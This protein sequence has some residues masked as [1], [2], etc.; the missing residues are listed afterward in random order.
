MAQTIRSLQELGEALGRGGSVDSDSRSHQTKD[1][2]SG[3]NGGVYHFPDKYR[4][5]KTSAYSHPGIRCRWDDQ[6]AYFSMGT[7]FM[8]LDYKDM[9]TVFPVY[10]TQENGLKK[11]TGFDRKPT[12][13]SAE[14]LPYLTVLGYLGDSDRRVCLENTEPPNSHTR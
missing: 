9:A 12:R 10:P 4:G 3:C 1:C 6:S 5:I 7:D 11:T 8:E 14:S 2:D 13:F